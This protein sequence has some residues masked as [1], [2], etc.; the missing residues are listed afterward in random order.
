MD[1]KIALNLSVFA[2]D[3]VKDLDLLDSLI[4]FE[5]QI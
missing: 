3:Q 4:V 5:Y 1:K 2:F